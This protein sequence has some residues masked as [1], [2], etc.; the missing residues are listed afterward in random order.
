MVDVVR[1]LILADKRLKIAVWLTTLLCPLNFFLIY[2]IL[3][4][5]KGT[6]ILQFWFR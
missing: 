5:C 2:I 6:Y 3:K 4:G 1:I